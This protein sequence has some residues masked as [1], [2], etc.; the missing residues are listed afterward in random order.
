MLTDFAQS[1][2]SKV[3]FAFPLFVAKSRRNDQLSMLEDC[4][5]ACRQQVLSASKHLVVSCSTAVAAMTL[6]IWPN[7]SIGRSGLC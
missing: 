7:F 1:R 4:R 2:W 5:Q 3:T 6:K